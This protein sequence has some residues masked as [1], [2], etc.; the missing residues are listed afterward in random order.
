MNPVSASRQAQINQYIASLPPEVRAAIVQ[1]GIQDARAILPT[2]YWSTVRFGATVAANTA[3]IAAGTQAK[4]FQYSI[5]Q[6]MTVAGFTTTTATGADTNLLRAGETLDNS[7]VYIYG[8]AA[9]PTPNSEP[10]ILEN[11]WRDCLVELSL[12][13]TSSIRLGT[14]NMFPG[15]G[16][17][18]GVGKSN[19]VLPSAQDTGRGADGGGGTAMSYLSNGNPMGGNFLRFPQPFKWCGVG[20]GGVDATL[21]IIV[22][23]TRAVSIP[24]AATRAAVAGGANTSGTGAWTQP[25]TGGVGTIA[26]IRFRLVS[27]SIAKRSVNT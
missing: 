8:L 21:S 17:L 10:R 5:G 27:V 12:N 7:D 6:D 20:T 25:A 2:P 22:T 14:L 9:D 3:T 1:S 18:Y 19:L 26:D 23:L 11:L 4:A 16:G 13:G 24:L 15:A